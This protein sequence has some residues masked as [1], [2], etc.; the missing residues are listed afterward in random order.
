MLSNIGTILTRFGRIFMTIIVVVVTMF[1]AKDSNNSEPS[2]EP[3]AWPTWV[4]EH[5]VWEN[6][7]T[8]ES[9]YDNMRGF[10]ERGIPVGAVIIDRPWATDSNTFITDPE[11]YPDLAEYVDKFHNEDV[12]VIMWATSMVNDTASNF[13]EGKDNGYFLSNGK[14][15]K[16]WGGQGALIDY[17]NPDAVQWWH[18]QMDNILDMGIDGWKVDGTDLHALLLLPASGLNDKFITWEEYR[19]MTYGDFFHYTRSKLGN[20]RVISARPVDDQLLNIGLPLVYTTRDINFA[21]WV[22]DNDNDWNGL[23]HALSCMFTSSMYNFVSYGSDI[24]GFRAKSEKDK[25][26]FLRWAQLGAFCAVMENGGSGE[27]SP[28]E[29]DEET[30]KIYRDAVLMHNQLIPYIY[31]QA[32]YSY[33]QVKPTMRP[34]LGDYIYLMGE[35][36]LVAPIFEEGN[37]RKVVFP[38]GEWISMYDESKT[39]SAGTQ[40]LGF[41]L[42]EFPAYIRKGAIVPMDV[43]SDATVYGTAL[44]SGY[45]TVQVYPAE[46]KTQFGLYEQDKKGAM[47]SYDKNGNSLTLGSTA[48]ERSLL[49]RVVGEGTPQAVTCGGTAMAKA[50]TMEELVT[51]QS[52]YF[53]DGS[54]TWYAVKDVNTGAEINVVYK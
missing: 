18:K 40:K 25:N 38:K 53:T 32:A 33:E 42:D 3:P 51:M 46:G 44:S 26:V 29:Y 45:T 4:H 19:N 17:T 48:T 22:G 28:W 24:G 36:V 39:Y 7:G 30:V 31:S 14:T 35:D 1:F 50:A 21:G 54:I 5:W 9:A 6:E 47:L 52:G 20:D 12:R 43:T 49:Y 10:T 16:W 2:L 34:Q 41:E 8:Q 15:V 37:E 27:H 13:Q 11:R 23:Q